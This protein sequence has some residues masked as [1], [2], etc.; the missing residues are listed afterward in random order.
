MREKKIFSRL[1]KRR[2]PVIMMLSVP[3]IFCLFL[4]SHYITP[5]IF[6]QIQKKGGRIEKHDAVGIKIL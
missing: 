1:T 6:V 4:L 2:V 5:I 3:N